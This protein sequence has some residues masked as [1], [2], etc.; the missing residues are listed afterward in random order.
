M[1][2]KIGDEASDFSLVNTSGE[3]TSLSLFRNKNVVILFFPFAYSSV[4]TR[5]MCTIQNDL[6]K[7]NELDAV[8]IGISVDSH[9]TLKMWAETHNLNFPLLSDFNKIVTAKYGVM[10]ELFAPGKFDYF[11][12]SKRAAFVVDKAGFIRYAEVIVTPDT[13]PNYIE[14]KK[15]LENFR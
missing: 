6:S 13:E 8:V 10:N 9:F 7:Y 1:E 12:V 3:K 15:T 11:G 4:C 14:I 5:E 2:L